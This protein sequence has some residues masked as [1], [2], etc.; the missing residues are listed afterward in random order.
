MTARRT[1]FDQQ[2]SAGW[3]L[4]ASPRRQG[5]SRPPGVTSPTVSSSRDFAR[6]G[7]NAEMVIYPD[8]IAV[9]VTV[10]ERLSGRS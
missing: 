7:P 5:R 4:R 8:H 1:R 6:R 9:A 3:S 10:L 2:E